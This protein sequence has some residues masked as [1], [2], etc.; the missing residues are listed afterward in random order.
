MPLSKLGDSIE[1]DRHHLADLLAKKHSL[2]V[3]ARQ[4]LGECITHAD[5]KVKSFELSLRH[6]FG[7]D[8]ASHSVSSKVGIARV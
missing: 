4:S 1:S 6:N 8:S 5:G 3:E 2:V 7:L